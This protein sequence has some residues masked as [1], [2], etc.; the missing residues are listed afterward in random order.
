MK[1]ETKD[2]KADTTER[3]KMKRILDSH[4]VKYTDDDLDK[5]EAF[6]AE[7]FADDEE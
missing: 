2:P 7:L 3:A 6:L 4:G 5:A 1:A